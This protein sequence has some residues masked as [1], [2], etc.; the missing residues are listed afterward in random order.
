MKVRIVKC[1]P[2]FGWYKDQIGSIF[3]VVDKPYYS[4]I[5]YFMGDS[6]GIHKEDCE[7][8]EADEPKPEPF[9]L[10]RALK[11]EKV[12]GYD[13]SIGEYKFTNNNLGD[14]V[15]VFQFSV[16]NGEDQAVMSFKEGTGWEH[17]FNGIKCAFSIT[18]APREPEYQTVWVNLYDELNYNNNSFIC[19]HAYINKS[20]AERNLA[21][22]GKPIGTFPITFKKP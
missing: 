11:G 22:A 3:N 12:V 10:G 1:T 9:D 5:M 7:I 4:D 14:I 2:I 13:G 20:E 16:N 17:G 19:S 21:N 18:M 15:H 6:H 8:L